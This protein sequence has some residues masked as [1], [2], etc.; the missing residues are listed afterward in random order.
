MSPKKLDI[1]HNGT[2]SSFRELKRVS[3]QGGLARQ[4]ED[5]L[6]TEVF[7]TKKVEVEAAMV[8][9]HNGQ[10]AAQAPHKPVLPLPHE[11]GQL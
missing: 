7:I 10:G 11:T 1:V 2:I 4:L 3:W 6:F 5:W 9:L 8:S